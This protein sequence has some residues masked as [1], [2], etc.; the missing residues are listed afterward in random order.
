MNITTRTGVIDIRQ[1]HPCSNCG[2]V[3]ET[4]PFEGRE[5]CDSCLR[6]MTLE[7]V[8]TSLAWEETTAVCVHKQYEFKGWYGDG[9]R[10]VEFLTML[11]NAP[12]PDPFIRI[13]MRLYFKR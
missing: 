8:K 4:V 7:R 1:P 12:L 2:H 3:S 6:P 13:A 11:V 9:L 5:L 10:A